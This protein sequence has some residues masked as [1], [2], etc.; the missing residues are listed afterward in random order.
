[1]GERDLRL[2]QQTHSYSDEDYLNLLR[3]RQQLQK[4]C[5]EQIERLAEYERTVLQMKTELE[6]QAQEKTGLERSLVASHHT[7]LTNCTQLQ[8]EVTRLEQ[9][10]T[11]LQLELANTHKDST[12]REQVLQMREMLLQQSEEDLKEARQEAERRSRDLEA[13]QEEVQRLQEE[14]QREEGALRENPNLRNHIRQ[15]S[16]E[17]EELHSKHRLTVADLAART[18][19]ARRMA[20]CLSEGKLAEEKRRLVVERLEREVTELTEVL[21]QAVEHRLKAEREKQHTQ[22]QADTLR[23][24]LEGTR[25]DNASL[26][27]ES[28]LVMSN[29]N[30]WIAE[31]KAS[32]ENLAAQIKTQNKVL[33]II[34]D[35][36]EHLQEANDTLKEELKALKEV[37]E[38]KEREMQRFKTHIRDQDAQ[39]DDRSRERESCV[40]LNLSKI[41]DMQTRLRNNLEA[42]RMLNQQTCQCDIIL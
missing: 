15:L 25:S 35:E 32:N 7:H 41:E 1:M 5:T 3:H 34:T 23:L 31:Q 39:R 36:K 9:E 17:L 18:E 8:Q 37:V 29:V 26:R 10:V 22:D 28:Q 6:R 42:I 13:L 2:Y 19:E 27:R 14:V 16:Q 40:A 4:R 33:V 38:E 24:G 12:Q 20:G 30:R 21:Q 11:R